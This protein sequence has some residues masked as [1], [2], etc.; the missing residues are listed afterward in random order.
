MASLC[1]LH[2]LSSLALAVFLNC[3]VFSTIGVGENWDDLSTEEQLFLED[4]Q[5]RTFNFF[6]QTTNPENGL[7]PDRWPETRSSSIAGTGFGLTAYCVGVERKF[8][9]R[10]QAV[11]RVLA[12]LDFF[13]NSL[14]SEDSINASGHRGFYYH[15]L[16][17]SGG[18]RYKSRELSSID[19]ALLM[20]GVLT[21]R[22]YFDRDTTNEK[23]I[24]DLADQL[25]LRVQWNWFQ[26][27]GPR[28]CMSWKPEEGFG[29]HEYRGY[30]ETM[31]LYLLALGS[32]TFPIASSAWDS[33]TSTYL[34]S[35]FFDQE[36]VNFTPL[37]G[38]Q[39]SHIWIDFR[40]IQ[41]TY[42]RKKNIDYFENSR[43][44][45]YAQ[46]S[47]ATSNPQNWADYSDTIWG[48]TACDG[49]GNKTLPYQGKQQR[50]HSYWARGASRRGIRDD[51][52]IAPAAAAGSIPFAP[53]I[54]IPA[55]LAMRDKYGDRLYT[56]YGF[57]DSFNPSFTFAE[58][59]LSHGQ[60][61]QDIGWVNTYYLGIDQGPIV[62]M[63]ENFRSGMIWDLMKKS[64]YL[65][66]GLK[67][68]KFSGGWLER[69][70]KEK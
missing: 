41:D 9:T 8:I 45:T 70:T 29:K 48:L 14:Q 33:Y 52:T 22:E 61:Y 32:P 11:E 21:C 27:H 50:F 58:E 69:I 37:F 26:P 19:T 13:W 2:R 6:W 18:K 63:I 54:T 39:F 57:L 24:R 47:Y 66:H 28:I 64:P 55:L 59:K 34:W 68:A 20:A 35:D 7:V 40:G 12:T 38:Y 65:I 53:E 43:R 56:Q 46:R 67:K 16:E 30:N 23:L 5:L 10:D 4:L 60:V 1:P 15:F 3:L 51:G 44:A 42:M 49:P 36:Y 25:Y 62:L 17:M 31:I